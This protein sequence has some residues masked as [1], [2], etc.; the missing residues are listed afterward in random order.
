MGNMKYYIPDLNTHANVITKCNTF[1][2]S[3]K[4][5]IIKNEIIKIHALCVQHLTCAS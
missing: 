3:P 2:S 1:V 5:Y 4:L